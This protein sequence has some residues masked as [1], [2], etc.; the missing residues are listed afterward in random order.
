MQL[1]A[2][3]GTPD[4]QLTYDNTE[5]GYFSESLDWYAA[6]LKCLDWGGNLAT[7]KSK[8]EDSLL[9][10]TTDIQTHYACYIGLNDILNEADNNESAFTWVDG[11]SSAYRNFQPGLP[12]SDS[13]SDD[14][15]C[16][17]FRFMKTGNVLSEGWLEPVCSNSFNCHFCTK[18]GKKSLYIY[19]NIIS[20]QSKHYT[21]LSSYF[22]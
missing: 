6:Q 11:S 12:R 2:S 18:P 19:I 1:F 20:K 7:I 16:V 13:S 9:Y 17:I 22:W 8:E 5:F 3:I 4:N 21:S 15:D 14:R 10:Y